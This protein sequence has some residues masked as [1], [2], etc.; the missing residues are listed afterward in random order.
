MDLPTA[1]KVTSPTFYDQGDI[2]YVHELKGNV[3]DAET[4][5][6][7]NDATIFLDK[8]RTKTNIDGEFKIRF[9]DSFFKG[10]PIKVIKDN[11][12]FDADSIFTYDLEKNTR[13][14]HHKLFFLKKRNESFV[15]DQYPKAVKCLTKDFD[16][17]FSFY[18]FPAAHWQH[19]RTTN[20]IESTFATIRL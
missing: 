18:D 8:Y 9:N 10:E 4:G 2:K 3:F 17:L 7:I 13:D 20:P 1:S 11:F 14:I 19:I 5:S 15:I 6:P 12:I 16:Q